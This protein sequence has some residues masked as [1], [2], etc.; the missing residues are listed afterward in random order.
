[1]VQQTPPPSKETPPRSGIRRALRWAGVSLLVLVVALGLGITWVTQTGHGRKFLLAQI[2][3]VLS[4]SVFT[5]TVHARRI[6]GPIF[7]QFILRDLTLSDDEERET[8]YIEEAYV[9]YTFTELVRKRLI[10]THLRIDGV[11]VQ[12]RIREDGSLNLARLFVPRDPNKPVK[13]KP[14]QGFAI[15]IQRLSLQG[16][17]IRIVDERVNELVIAFSEPRLVAD[18]DM[19]GR[20]QMHAGISELASNISFGLALGKEFAARIDDLSVDLDPKQI[21]FSAERLTVGETGLFGFDGSI[22]RSAEGDEKPFEY[23]E[24]R[25]PQL[26]FSPEEI[27]ALVPSLPLATTLR[28]DATIEGPPEDV[29]LRAALQGA[30]QGATAEVKLNLSAGEDVGLRGVLLVEEFKPELWLDLPGVTG[31]V[32]AAIRF[33]MQGLTP[34]RLRA[35]LE[36]QIEPSTLLGYKLDSGILRLG[37]AQNIATLDALRFQAGTASLSGEGQVA[38]SGAVDLQVRLDAPNLADLAES[39][40]NAP[41]LRGTVHGDITAKGEIP[42]ERLNGDALKSVDGIIEHVVR[43]LDVNATIRAK[44]M[45]VNDLA[46]GSGDVQL[47]GIRGDRLQTEL[48]AAMDDVVVGG[49][50]IDFAN[51]EAAVTGDRLRLEGTARAMRTD[52]AIGADGTWSTTKVKLRLNE[53]GVAHG[54]VRGNLQK[55]ARIDVDLSEEGALQQ[56]TVNDFDFS[57]PGTTL[58]LDRVRYGGD[59]SLSGQFAVRVDEV[60]DLLSILGQDSLKASGAVRAEGQIAGTIRRPRYVLDLETRALRG[61]DFGPVTGALHVGQL[62]THL[63]INGLL[64]LGADPSNGPVPPTDCDGRQTL[65]HADA[66]ILPILPGF[67]K[68]GPRFDERGVLSGYVE[69]GP[70]A[71]E[72]VAEEIEAAAA[73]KPRGIVGLKMFLDGSFQHPNV[74]AILS[75]Q[76]FW[77]TIPLAGGKQPV[78]F[79]PV[80][81]VMNAKLEDDGD[82]LSVARWGLGGKGLQVGGQTWLRAHGD[83]RA[84]VRDFLLEKISMR[85]LVQQTWGAPISLEIPNR[86]LADLPEGLLPKEL[87][88]SGSVYLSL[89]VTRTEDFAGAKLWFNATDILWEDIGPLQLFASAVSA[90]DTSLVVNVESLQ[91]DVRAALDA[92]LHVSLLDLLMRGIAP[93]DR[94]D[95][96]LHVP[97]MAL[98]ELPS[99]SVRD[100]VNEILSAGG[101]TVSPE[102]SGYVDVSNT[103][104]DLRANGRFQLSKITTAKGSTTE[105]GVEFAFAPANVLGFSGGDTP[106]LQAMFTVCGPNQS[107]ALQLYAS[108]VPDVRSGALIFGDEQARAR[109][110]EKLKA[111]PYAAVLKAREAPLAALAPAWLLMDVATNVDGILNADLRVEGTLDHF[112]EARGFMELADAQG[113]IIP[114]ARRIEELDLRIL[115]GPQGLRMDRLY[116]NDGVGTINGAGELRVSRGRPGEAE[117]HFDFQRFLLADASGIGVFLTAGVP[118]TATLRKTGIDVDVRLDNADIYVPDSAT[119]GSSGGPTTVPENVVFLLEDQSLSDYVEQVE[120]QAIEEKAAE[121]LAKVSVPIRVHVYSREDARVRQRFADLS[122]DVDMNLRLEGGDIFTTGGVNVSSGYAQVVGKRFDVTL[123]RVLFDGGGDGPFDPRLRI[124]AVHRLPRKT[125]SLLAAPSGQFASVSVVMDTHVSQLNVELRSDPPMSESDILNVLLTGKPIETDGEARPE[126]LT[127]AGTLLA[128]FL[129]DQLGTNPVIDNLSVELDDSDGTLDSR[130]E[131]G[132]YFGKDNSIYASIA[133]IAGADANT[134]SVEVSWQFILAQL[135]ASSLRLELRWGNRRTGAAE[136]LYDLRL[137]KGLRFVR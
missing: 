59:G 103:L 28:V 132:R 76:D 5:G 120:R 48:Q 26:V 108:A 85:S 9:R 33:A 31:D 123:G 75:L 17:D 12:G 83:V 104:D 84:P 116:L 56:V 133:Y 111:S 131:G 61:M 66:L 41:R 95:A 93:A 36:V 46:V 34:Q 55:P 14:E 115:L 98:S 77:L 106:R 102:I 127:T 11:R 8:A 107:C 13:E 73:Y 86:P 137:D 124:N 37:Y 39:A 20:G 99:G 19:D 63:E 135:R 50:T 67:T 57:G 58:R 7:G 90:A 42:F 4:N 129:T 117:L 15:A 65:L 89:D 136:F 114:L 3:D 92:T 10:I 29:A 51:L 27:M 68:V 118:I 1:M 96:R 119:S 69:I 101:P 23:F 88:P 79:G 44:G 54:Q 18:F 110:M 105:A 82:S 121:R 125:A 134:N 2:S 60:R 32:N 122:L 126:A 91:T 71:I 40:P 53:L 130:F 78:E 70:L 109:A 52:L 94:L 64:C 100:K 81:T 87:D 112:P 21:A 30:D 35:G 25:M 45:R 80:S 113:E 72:R 16:T 62:A 43:H 47:R 6:D 97:T 128:G 38:L 74:A 22:Q 24:A 49:T